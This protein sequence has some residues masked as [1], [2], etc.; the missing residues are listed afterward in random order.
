MRGFCELLL[1]ASW[2][3]PLCRSV[4]AVLA[5]SAVGAPPGIRSLSRACSWLTDRT[6]WAATIRSPLFQQ[7]EHHR[8]VLWDNYR[9][10]ALERC[11]TG[12]RS[13]I[14]HV[15]L[16]STSPRQLTHTGGRRGRRVEH[17]LVLG[18]K[19]L[20]EMTPQTSGV[21]NRPP[22]ILELTCPPQQVPIA[23]Q[24]G[25]DLQ[26]THRR[27]PNRVHCRSGVAALVCIQLR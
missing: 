25:I 27:V 22:S 21:L 10:V 16:A 4:A 24:G 15:V 12:G 6:R 1:V 26:R 8:R 14:D 3:G 20:S 13:S 2:D 17:F 5:F 9:S 19:P 23:R 11:N 7:C 18:D